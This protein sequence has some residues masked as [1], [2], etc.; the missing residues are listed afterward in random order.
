MNEQP[1]KEKR[2]ETEW[3]FSFDKL[4]D[5]IGD[6]FKSLGGEAELRSD[7][8]SEPLG[9]ATSARVR[10]HLPICQTTVK[11]T[12]GENLIEA[13]L[14]HIGEVD[15]TVTGEGE[16]FVNLSQRADPADWVR[17]MFSWIGT[18]GKLHWDIGLTNRIPVELDIH[19]GVGDSTFDLR[20]MNLTAL[21]V[22]GGAGKFD[23]TLPVSG[24]HYSAQI[25]GGLGEFEVS[26]P[27]EAAL[28]LSIRAGTGEV[29][30]NVGA[31][32]LLNAT[33]RGGVG[34]FE[35]TLPSGTAAR[36]EAKMGLGDIHLPPNFMRTSGD[37]ETFIGK[38]GVWQTADYEAS[39]RRVSLVFEGG[40]GELKVKTV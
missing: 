7:Q 2:Y 16:K 38:T 29:N 23:L 8:L 31:N 22:Y 9:G 35:V 5:Q 19:N 1:E 30:L 28:D 10:L 13:N 36:V 34:D 11:S 6:F 14:T 33:I 37:G 20:G 4:N 27:A 15:F 40:V 3:S 18:E 39:E 25:N 17:N 24:G 12:A 32:T 26:V 21:S